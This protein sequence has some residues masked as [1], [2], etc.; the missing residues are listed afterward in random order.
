MEELAFAG[1]YTNTQK[2]RNTIYDLRARVSRDVDHH[3][4]AWSRVFFISNTVDV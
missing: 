3:S 1:G 4:D 2:G